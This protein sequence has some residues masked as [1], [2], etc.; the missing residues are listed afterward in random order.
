V[1]AAPPPRDFQQE[2]H[3]RTALGEATGKIAFHIGFEV[4]GRE[5]KQTTHAAFGFSRGLHDAHVLDRVWKAAVAL[6]Q[7]RWQ[8]LG[9][10]SPNVS[11]MRLWLRS[12]LVRA[13][14]SLQ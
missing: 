5:V 1:P 14:Q 10:T 13:H 12:L 3:G 7:Y 2:A 8:G 4:S 6:N 11:S 9:V